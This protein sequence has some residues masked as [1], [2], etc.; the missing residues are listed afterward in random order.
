MQGATVVP[1]GQLVA[2]EPQRLQQVADDDRD[3]RAQPQRLLDDRVEVL[4][5]TGFEVLLR[6]CSS[7]S[8]LRSSR[9]KVQA[10]VLEVGPSE[11]SVT[12]SSRRSCSESGVPSS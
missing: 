4:A 10:S 11:S 1:A 2:A 7:L 9:S 8:G 5:V 12:S 6:V 3:R